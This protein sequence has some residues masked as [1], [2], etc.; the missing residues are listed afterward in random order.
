MAELW[1]TARRAFPATS[2]D[3]EK[4]AAQYIQEY[5]KLLLD[6]LKEIPQD[7]QGQYTA[8]FKK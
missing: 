8:K 5:E 3:P 4:R 1:E 2:F 7:E 6:D